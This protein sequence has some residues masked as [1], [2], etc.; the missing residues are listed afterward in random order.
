MGRK[1][2]GEGLGCLIVIGITIWLFM[3]YPTY[4]WIGV[5]VIV[6]LGILIAI[7]SGPS[8]CQVCR[9]ELKKT[10]YTWEIQGEKKTVCPKCNQRLQSKKSKQAVDELFK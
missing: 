6:V 7:G 5:G 8:T 3:E 2:S 10:K 1:K 4:A 9:A